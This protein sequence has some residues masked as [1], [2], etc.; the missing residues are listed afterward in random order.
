MRVGL[1]IGVG[2]CAPRPLEQPERDG[3][4]VGE[5]RPECPAVG[6]LDVGWNVVFE[7]FGT[8]ISEPLRAPREV[9]V[10]PVGESEGEDAVVDGCRDVVEVLADADEEAEIVQGVAG[11][12]SLS[13]EFD[14][15][16][17]VFAGL[18]W[19]VLV[20]E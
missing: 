12:T 8:P 17:D 15:G 14:R 9:L 18:F 19:F 20:V 11:V 6:R 10:G 4:L 16:F 13:P 1:G 7:V 2:P 3:P 5:K